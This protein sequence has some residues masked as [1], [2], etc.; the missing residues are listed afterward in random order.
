MNITGMLA[1][2][3]GEPCPFCTTIINEDI[4]IVA[5]LVNDH[6]EEFKE[7]LLKE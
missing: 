1:I 2:G 5:H 6:P 4:D 3:N 7:A